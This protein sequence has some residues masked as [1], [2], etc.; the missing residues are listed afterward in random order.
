VVEGR[1]LPESPLA[2]ADQK[3][4][5]ILLADDNVD[6]TES[7]AMLLRDFG[8]VVE[9]VEDGEAALSAAIDEPPDI[10]FLDIGMP[11]LNGFEVAKQFRAAPATSGVWLVA[12]TGWG[13]A[14]YRQASKEA[15]FDR[16]LVKPVDPDEV[17]KLIEELSDARS[18]AAGGA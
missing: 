6:L 17:H 2:G 8:H 16:H 10:A 18:A 4:L 1:S 14:S 5:R 12:V 13:Q 15:G 3:G 7:F 11:K 9:V